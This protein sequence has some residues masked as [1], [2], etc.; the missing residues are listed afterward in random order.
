MHS[1]MFRCP[2]VG[3]HTHVMLS[4]RAADDE[5]SSFEVVKCPACQAMHLLNRTTGAV[6]GHPASGPPDRD[7]GS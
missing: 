6:L 7:S 2:R 4:A 5:V 3:F 1:V